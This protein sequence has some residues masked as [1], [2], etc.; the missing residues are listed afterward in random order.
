MGIWRYR[1]REWNSFH[2]ATR[3]E[4]TLLPI[5][6]RMILPGTIINSDG[7]RAYANIGRMD[8][9]VYEHRVVVHRQ[10]FVDPDDDSVHT[11][12]IESVGMRAKKKL[13]RQCGTSRELFQLYLDE[14]LWREHTKNSNQFSEFLIC[15]REQF[16]V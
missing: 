2:R 16:V 8:G 6:S 13:R 5:I 7:W 4:E 1:K 10:H 3:D 15:V 9:G 14:F 11:Q 12:S